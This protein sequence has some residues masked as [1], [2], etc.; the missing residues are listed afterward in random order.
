MT[1]EG[2]SVSTS[3][4]ISLSRVISLLSYLLEKESAQMEIQSSMDSFL[5]EKLPRRKY[6]VFAKIRSKQNS[7]ILS[8]GEETG[9]IAGQ[10]LGTHYLLKLK[11]MYDL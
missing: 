5:K 4:G 2:L 8:T 1:L 6:Q 9:V 7:S 11:N 10:L 3:V